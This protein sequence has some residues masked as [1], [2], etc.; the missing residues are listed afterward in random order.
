MQESKMA[1]AFLKTYM[2]ININISWRDI[3]LGTNPSA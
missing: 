1:K 3:Q 2:D